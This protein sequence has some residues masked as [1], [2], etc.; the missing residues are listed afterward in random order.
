ML[1]NLVIFNDGT[2]K[3]ALERCTF[4]LTRCPALR[5]VAIR[6]SVQTFQN[7]YTKQEFSK[8]VRYCRVHVNVL[9]RIHIPY[10]SQVDP[11]FVLIGLH[12]LSTLRADS[13]P[14]AQFA[15]AILK[16]YCPKSSPIYAEIP[17]NLRIFPKEDRFCR[18]TFERNCHVN[19]AVRLPVEEDDLAEV[20]KRV[21][22]WF[23]N[24]L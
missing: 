6:C 18:H 12:F 22:G 24:G 23:E 11:N 4:L 16:A 3:D 5:E 20:M 14:V 21:K 15:Q 1:Y 9:V 10:W 8:M 2:K 17:N 7:N 19:P 13:I